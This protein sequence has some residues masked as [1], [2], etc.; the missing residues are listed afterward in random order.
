MSWKD[1]RDFHESLESW[2][3]ASK[4]RLGGYSSIV[5]GLR[6]HLPRSIRKVLAFLTWPSQA[7]TPARLLHQWLVAPGPMSTVARPPEANAKH[8]TH[9]RK[10]PSHS[11]QEN[12]GNTKRDAFKSALCQQA[13]LCSALPTPCPQ[14]TSSRRRLAGQG[15][16]CS[17]E[18]SAMHTAPSELS[19]A[20][21]DFQRN[22][23]VYN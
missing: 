13:A 23:N 11:G 22:L 8:A 5:T 1:R 19:L 21:S 17:T 4:G 2:G 7:G 16:G 18:A 9:L 10:A 15:R 6:I 12:S 3:V 14:S 20:E